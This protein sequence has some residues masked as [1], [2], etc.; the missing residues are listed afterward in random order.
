VSVD[1]ENYLLPT[2]I[3]LKTESDLDFNA[4]SLS[5]LLRQ[6]RREQRVNV[7]ILDACRDNPFAPN[8]LRTATRAVVVERGLTRIEGDLVM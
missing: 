1:D 5:L 6:M 8:L 4:F 3:A 2:D 7:V